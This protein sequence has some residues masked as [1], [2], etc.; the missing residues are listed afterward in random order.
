M[1][2]LVESNRRPAA[3]SEG[4][5]VSFVVH[6]LVFS[7]VVAVSDRTATELQSDVSPDTGVTYFIPEDRVVHPPPKQE[8][9]SWMDIGLGAGNRGFEL[10]DIDPDA[11]AKAFIVGNRKSKRNPAL[12]E[13]AFEPQLPSDSV[14]SV[15]DVDSAVARYPESAAP[16]YPA[17]LLAQKIEGSAQ[18]QF[19]VDTTGLADTTSFEVIWTTHAAFANAVRDALPYM[20]FRPAVLRS[21]RVRQLVQQPFVFRI[22][23]PS[24][25]AADSVSGD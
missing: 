16:A 14:M 3:L 19:V 6:A 2:R 15:L 22:L 24:A 11:S 12:D 4:A 9:I 18:V 23:A 7:S 5:V 21:R 1:L 13:G 20:R 17:D 8:R 25:A 10:R